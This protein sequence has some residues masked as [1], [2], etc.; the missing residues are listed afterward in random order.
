MA[1][2]SYEQHVEYCSAWNPRRKHVRVSCGQCFR[3]KTHCK[4]SPECAEGAKLAQG[5]LNTAI[6]PDS[7]GWP[8]GT[9]FLSED[10]Y[11]ER[12]DA[13]FAHFTPPAREARE[14]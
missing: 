6:G 7:G 11:E 10:D 4:A 13:Y 12:R 3:C 8:D 14:P 1:L 2:E 9:E 5:Y